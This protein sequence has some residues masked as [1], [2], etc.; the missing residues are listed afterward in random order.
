VPLASEDYIHR[1]GRTARAEMTGEAY[2][3]V[4]PAEEEDLRSIE[5]AVGKRLPRVTLPD[6]D[7]S[8][9]PVGALE[10]PLK[11]RLAAHRAQRSGER[12][13]QR[14]NEARRSEPRPSRDRARGGSGG[15]R[16]GSSAGR[17][18]TSTGRPAVGSGRPGAGSSSGDQPSRPVGAASGGNRRGGS[19]G[20][21]RDGAPASGDTRRRRGASG[22]GPGPY[23]DGG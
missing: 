9:K 10:I 17:P 12:E 7:Y 18:G 3:F 16:G 1:V 6:F 23:R 22:R 20:A 21:P 5:K 14:N 11:E 8:A 4:S 13:R 2:T 19:G 15:G